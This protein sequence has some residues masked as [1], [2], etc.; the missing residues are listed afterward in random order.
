MRDTTDPQSPFVLNATRIGFRMSMVNTAS[1][2]VLLA[3]SSEDQRRALL[4][5]HAT[6]RN[7]QVEEESR[8]VMQCGRTF[9]TIRERGYDVLPVRNGRQTAIAVP[10]VNDAGMPVAA[11]ALRY[12][13]A[14]MPYTEAL[15]RFVEPL[16][17]TAQRIAGEIDRRERAFH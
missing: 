9:D 3:L 5:Q 12:F 1:G 11:L 16:S 6:A 7:V 8:A 14:A 15:R 10:V 17:R 13:N 2:R 4:D